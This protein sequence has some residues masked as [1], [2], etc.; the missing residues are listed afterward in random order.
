[1]IIV[2]NPYNPFIFDQTEK[3][4]QSP[5]KVADEYNNFRA[6]MEKMKNLPMI[7]ISTMG[8]TEMELENDEFNE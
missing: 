5:Q 8:L 4:Y 7:Y 3:I 1:M 6:A 2:T